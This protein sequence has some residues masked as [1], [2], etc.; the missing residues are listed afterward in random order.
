METEEPECGKLS[1]FLNE[2]HEI[3]EKATIN[4]LKA[5]EICGILL[6]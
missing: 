1:D 2:W 6:P 3:K 4:R 5:T